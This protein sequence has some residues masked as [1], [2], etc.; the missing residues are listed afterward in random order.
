VLTNFLR[1]ARA[2]GRLLDR[3]LHIGAQHFPFSRRR[4]RA[5]SIDKEDAGQQ[6]VLMA[7]EIIFALAYHIA[8]PSEEAVPPLPPSN[9]TTSFPV[10][11]IVGAVDLMRADCA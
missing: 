4:R 9:R 11:M 1:A 8:P 3:R 7:P 5:A 2:S 10:L 6:A